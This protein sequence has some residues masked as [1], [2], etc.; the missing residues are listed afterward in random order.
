MSRGILEV[1]N[2]GAMKL[3]IGGDNYSAA[4][5]SVI[6]AKERLNWNIKLCISLLILL[7][8]IVIMEQD[9]PPFN[10]YVQ[11]VSGLQRLRWRPKYNSVGSP[12]F[13]AFTGA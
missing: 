3:D 8:H 10:I 7:S 5:T 6:E 1:P 9:G 13:R 12:A 2:K 4:E 11:K